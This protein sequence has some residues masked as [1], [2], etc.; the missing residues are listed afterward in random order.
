[1]RTAEMPEFRA[2]SFGEKD[3]H[4]ELPTKRIYDTHSAV[5]QC[6]AG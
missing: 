1:M 3:D 6:Q 2:F 5:T 4:N